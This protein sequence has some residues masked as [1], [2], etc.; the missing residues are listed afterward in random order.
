MVNL[1]AELWASTL[2]KDGGMFHIG[3]RFQSSKK[4][5]TSEEGGKSH[6]RENVLE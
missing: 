1:G 5:T 3:L 6:P 2:R 4:V